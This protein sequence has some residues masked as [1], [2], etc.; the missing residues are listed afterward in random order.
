MNERVYDGYLKVD[1]VD[2]D[3]GDGKL[4]KREV[5]RVRDAVAVLCY[6]PGTDKFLFTKQFR[7]GANAETFEVPAGC[8][9]KGENPVDAAI[10]ET[11]EE[12][13]REVLY[14]RKAGEFFLSPGYT[15]EKMYLY[16]ACVGEDNLG[17]HLDGDE[18]LT[19]V[20]MSPRDLVKYTFK[21]IKTQYLVNSF[22]L[23]Q[24]PLISE[25]N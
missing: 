21:D 9:D 13:G 23:K 4:V 19:I 25:E 18:F 2:V 15:T 17:Q 10:R 12:T 14:I 11:K 1:R 8:I 22:A 3:L 6:C 16:I 24:T 20:E 5:V 7:I